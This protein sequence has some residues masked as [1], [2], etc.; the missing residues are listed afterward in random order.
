MTNT[1]YFLHIDSR[2]LPLCK[3]F[4]MHSSTCTYLASTAFSVVTTKLGLKRESIGETIGHA[5]GLANWKLAVG[6]CGS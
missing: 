4:I 2:H 5:G 6:T 3:K 1:G